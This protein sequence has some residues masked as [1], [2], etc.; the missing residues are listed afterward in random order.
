M[1]E[2]GP[3]GKW[4]VIRNIPADP[5]GVMAVVESEAYRVPCMAHNPGIP[6]YTKTE[7]A[8]LKRIPHSASL[9]RFAQRVKGVFKN[10]RVTASKIGKDEHEQ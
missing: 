7:L 9:F 10:A 5:G 2:L 8:L 1:S 6:V 4:A 3:D